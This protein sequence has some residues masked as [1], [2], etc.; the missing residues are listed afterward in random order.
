MTTGRRA[1]LQEA[2]L[3]EWPYTEAGGP[4]AVVAI[5]TWSGGYVVAGHSLPPR[6]DIVIFASVLVTILMAF[7][8]VLNGSPGRGGSLPLVIIRSL[9]G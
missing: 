2:R 8:A 9:F 4:A 7:V 5:Q 6:Y 3:G 1:R